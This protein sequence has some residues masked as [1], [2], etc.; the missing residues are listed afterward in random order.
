MNL[1]ISVFTTIINFFFFGSSNLQS[2]NWHCDDSG[3]YTHPK[4]EKLKLIENDF[5]GL[6]QFI[7]YA[8]RKMSQSGYQTEI[9]EFIYMININGYYDSA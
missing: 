4:Y 1:N 8:G 6:I 2:K 5:M 7:I 3:I 9:S